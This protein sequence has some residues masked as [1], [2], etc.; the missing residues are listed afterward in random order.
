MARER[1]GKKRILSAFLAEADAHGF[2]VLTRENSSEYFLRYR[3]RVER[4]YAL[5][6]NGHPIDHCETCVQ[7]KREIFR[8]QEQLIL[9][10]RFFVLWVL[11]HLPGI[12][13]RNFLDLFFIGL[14]EGQRRAIERHNPRFHEGIPLPVRLHL[15][16]S[17][18]EEWSVDE[19][20]EGK[21]LPVQGKSDYC[22]YARYWII[23]AISRARSDE[24]FLRV[25]RVPVHTEQRETTLY[26]YIRT[27][28]ILEGNAPS[29]D[30]LV[31]YMRQIWSDR[32]A[33]E[34]A[35]ALETLTNHGLPVPLEWVTYQPSRQHF[36]VWRGHRSPIRVAIADH[37]T[38]AAAEPLLGGRELFAALTRALERIKTLCERF[39]SPYEGLILLMRLRLIQSE[40]PTLA[41]VG[42]FLGLSRERI[43]Q[44]EHGAIR[45]IAKSMHM[46]PG[47]LRHFRLA[48]EGLADLYANGDRVFPSYDPSEGEMTQIRRESP[49]QA[50]E[51]FSERVSAVDVNP[52][53]DALCE[54]WSDP[55][56]P[57]E[58]ALA[59]EILADPLCQI[60]LLQLYAAPGDK[61]ELLVHSP[62]EILMQEGSLTSRES[63]YVLISLRMS[64]WITFPP[65]QWGGPRIIELVWSPSMATNA[66]QGVSPI[67]DDDLI[68]LLPERSESEQE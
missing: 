3:E 6:L 2:K 46:E 28:R 41:Q 67:S 21:E 63:Q 53:L 26:R 39:C 17:G 58:Q 36:S 10:H 44:L 5:R 20:V 64:E 52:S 38:S 34:S 33:D 49:I 61:G 57:D 47:E 23:H 59:D 30:D 13:R 9:G 31:V 42:D 7:A 24:Y 51:E 60:R 8:L 56:A 11:K 32:R 25:Y 55:R 16:E 54:Q 68:D 27:Q 18:G 66:P 43:R 65:G 15:T 12:P 48:Y 4:L 14:Y 29:M 62:I 37:V 50:L 45:K 1:P 40:A 22:T 19:E 35:L